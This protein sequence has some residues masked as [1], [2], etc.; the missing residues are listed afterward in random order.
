MIPTP[1]AVL[2]MMGRRQRSTMSP[3][4]LHDRT[5]DP[6]LFGPDSVT[7]RVMRE[8]ILML[9]AGRA[10]LMQAA[11]PLVAQGALDHSNYAADPYGRLERTVGWVTVVCFGTTDE[12]TRATAGVV[13]IHRRVKGRVPQATATAGVPAGT[14]YTAQ[15]PDLL[16]WVHAS[17]V[18]TMLATH[19]AL[20][21]G[22]DD[23]E[24]DAF[25]HEWDAVAALFGLPR[26]L[27]WRDAHAM[28]A[29]VAG[30][31]ERGPAQPGPGSRRVAET[32]LRP[33]VSS[34]AL[35]PAAELLAFI[36]VGL[37]PDQVR[38]GYGL[39]WT[40]AHAA[41]H[42]AIRVWLRSARHTMPRRFRISPVYDLALARAR[43]NWPERLA[44]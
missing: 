17:F 27:L 1:A 5:A 15:D 30:Q 28:R 7:W 38:R 3:M 10:L 43:G 13:S 33:P 11:N 36:A 9:G 6:G 4:P 40:P 16:R 42:R 8:P 35:R 22:L 23:D 24:R 34:R 41:A 29:Y 25:V 37:L 31:V 18:E 14:V 44:A 21:G 19:D 12:A 26:R 32:V 39:P 20:V 2:E